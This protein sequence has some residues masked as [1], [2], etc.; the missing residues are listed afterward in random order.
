MPLIWNKYKMTKELGSGP[1]I[2]TYLATLEPII[3]EI[4][5]KDKDSQS[6][7][8]DYFEKLKDELKIYEIIEEDD[9]IYLVA[10]K[11]EETNKK[12]DDIISL[13]EYN[14]KKESILEGQGDP[15]TKEEILNLFKLE[16]SMCKI[17]FEK[18]VNNE[19]KKGK[20]TGFF[21]EIENEDFP[22]KYCLLTNNHVLSEK[23]VEINKRIKFEYFT[24]TKYV[25]KEIKITKDRKVFTNKELDYTCIEIFK[26]DCIKKYFKIEPLLYNSKKN[27]F[28][29]GQDI[30]VLQFPK[31]NEM[32]FS[33]G[34]IKA[35]NENK[36]A[37]TASTDNGSSGSP[38]IRRCKEN[39]V[40]GLH[41]GGNKNNNMATKINSILE[42]ISEDILKPNEINCIYRP[43][44]DEKEIS[45]IHNYSENIGFFSDYSDS[46]KK[47]Y[48]EAKE[49]NYNLFKNKIE[50]Y[51]NGEK[52]KFDFKFKIK[53]SKEIK[54]KFKFKIKL[55][56]T[57]Y[58][59]YK[60]SALQSIDLSLFKTSNVINMGFMFYICSSLKSI[61][62]S[63][64]NTSNVTNMESM[65]RD[66]SSLKSIDLSSFNTS[67][68]EYMLAMFWSC[69]SLKK[70]NIKI[71]NK[72]DKLLRLIKEYN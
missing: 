22:I 1:N 42:D 44:E 71:N 46:F 11:D 47:S 53:D 41:F 39:Y 64:F 48:S 40:I 32:S 12:I 3:K 2:K 18:I 8:Y 25:E 21:C 31:G 10:E 15:M 4:I 68:V 6:A 55:T 29:K 52:I 59:F 36:L 34:K 49:I 38:I 35:V 66:C 50:M 69:S 65:F 56:N 26:S 5:P 37:H 9:R 19:I 13:D 57:S 63:S 51:V 28:L 62:L 17:R 61:D 20:G 60:C 72:N 43:K 27:D 30:F 54:V 16:E 14:I 33:Y 24:G 23:N 70:E 7:I 58:M 45:I 67:N